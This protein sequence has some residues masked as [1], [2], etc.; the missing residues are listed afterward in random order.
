[1]KLRVLLSCAVLAVSLPLVAQAES[2]HQEREAHPRLSRAI[3]A[4]QDAITELKEAP[5]DFGGHKAAAVAD[6][7]KAL[8]SLREALK[9][10]EMKDAQQGK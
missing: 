1:M 9:Y 3:H 7:E 6:S 8:A 10:R 2:Y 5:D 4:L